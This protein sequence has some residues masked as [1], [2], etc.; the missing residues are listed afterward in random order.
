[1]P[2]VAVLCWLANR[3]ALRTGRRGWMWATLLLQLGQTYLHAIG[4]F[5]AAFFALAALLEQRRN[6]DRRRLV[7]WFGVQTLTLLGMLPV[8]ASALVRGTEPLGAPTLSSVLVYPAEA[9]SIWGATPPML[10]AG[11]ATFLVLLGLALSAPRNRLATLVICCGPLATAIILGTLGKTIFKPPVFAASITP[12]LALG[13]AG[14]IAWGRTAAYRAVGA[15]CT[16]VLAAGLWLGTVHRQ[17]DETYRPAA[18]YLAANVR[19]GDVVVI[20]S[21]SVYWGILRYAVGPRW[22]HPLDIMPLQVNSQ[23]TRLTEKLGPVWADRL[24][25]IPKSNLVENGGVRYVIGGDL[26]RLEPAPA[27]LWVVHRRLYEERG[28]EAITP[29]WPTPPVS[30]ERFGNELAVTL[31]DRGA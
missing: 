27:R 31:M 16:L 4:F 1:M 26:S 20:P 2:G 3:E 18:D 13:A 21:P 28:Q 7:T 9:L 30:I 15:T 12:F 29:S 8:I 11:G 6:L 10:A 19:A 22:G 24:G 17:A 23:W 14:N 5:F 25:L